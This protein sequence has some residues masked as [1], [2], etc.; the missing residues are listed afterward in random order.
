MGE[1]FHT[2]LKEFKEYLTKIE[3][4]NSATSVL[5]WDMMANIPK[6][7]KPY[8]SEVLGYLS[9]ESYILQTSDEMKAFIDYFISRENLDDITKAMVD[10]AKKNYY[11]TKKMNFL[12]SKKI[13]L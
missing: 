5:S 6:K 4:L 8:R 10:N 3:Y 1:S 11:Q 12:R 13:H 2:K 9:S 7:G